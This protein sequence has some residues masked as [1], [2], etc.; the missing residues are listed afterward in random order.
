MLGKNHHKH[1]ILSQMASP[2]EVD[3]V[4]K[5]PERSWKVGMWLVTATLTGAVLMALEMITFRLYAP[6]F[7][8][9]IYVWGGMIS[10]VLAAMAC[11]YG[12]GG[13]VADRSRDDMLLYFAIL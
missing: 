13:W 10:V 6:H 1:D 2:P 12:L 9:S 5:P 11:G 7:G 3:P 4:N 8:Y